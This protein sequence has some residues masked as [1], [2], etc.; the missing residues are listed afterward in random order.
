[1]QNNII[2]I[3]E[4]WVRAYEPELQHQSAEWR[5]KFSQNPSPVKFMVILAYDVQGVIL[6]HFVPHSETVHAQ[7]YAA[8]MQNHLRRAV[9]HERPKL[10]NV[11]ILHHNATPH[12]AIFVR[13][14]L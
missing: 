9:R 1:M 6:C 13:D 4:T 5:Q 2:T 14:L 11:F 7:Y 12:K 8:Y 3:D 10:Q